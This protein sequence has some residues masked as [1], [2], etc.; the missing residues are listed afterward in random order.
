MEDIVIVCRGFFIVIDYYSWVV[1]L[2]LFR[3]NKFK[4]KGNI[5]LELDFKFKCKIKGF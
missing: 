1:K 4:I 5:D 2:R 3:F